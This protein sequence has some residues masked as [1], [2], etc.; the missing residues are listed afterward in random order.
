MNA[1][2]QAINSIGRDG[3]Y[4]RRSTRDS[5]PDC[6]ASPSG[7]QSIAKCSTCGSTGWLTTYFFIPIRAIIS[8][9]KLES[10]SVMIGAVVVAGDCGIAITY[11]DF[12]SI[13]TDTDEF[14]VDDKVMKLESIVPSDQNALYLLG[15]VYSET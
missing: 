5:C 10:K 7:G 3:A 13:N 12:R 9:R 1:A 2:T 4:L 11:D 8:W 15:L 14:V 6:V